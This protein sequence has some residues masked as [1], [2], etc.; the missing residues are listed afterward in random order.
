M[1]KMVFVIERNAS[2]II[3]DLSEDPM[4]IVLGSHAQAIKHAATSLGNKS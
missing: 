4:T 3:H 2:C 1:T